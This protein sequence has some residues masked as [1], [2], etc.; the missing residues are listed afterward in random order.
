LIDAGISNDPAKM[1]S[2][3]A[4]VSSVDDPRVAGALA[5]L[6]IT[7]PALAQQLAK[8][9]ASVED[10]SD[11]ASIISNGKGDPVKTLEKLVAYNETAGD[12]L[13]GTTLTKTETTKVV[14]TGEI[15]VPVT[16]TLISTCKKCSRATF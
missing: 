6:V 11:A 13:K 3:V 1:S 9:V 4:A 16:S 12:S 2:V 5:S 7:S 14:T 8:I 15:I 10:R